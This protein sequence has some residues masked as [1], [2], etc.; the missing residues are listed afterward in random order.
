MGSENVVFQGA[1]IRGDFG[2]IKIGAR[3][4]FQDACVV[5]TAE[6]C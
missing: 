6:G 1:I 2:K 3:N 5:N 4:V